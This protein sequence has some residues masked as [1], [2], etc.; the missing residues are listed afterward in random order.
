MHREGIKLV[1]YSA[2][3]LTPKQNGSFSGAS[4]QL[5]SDRTNNGQLFDVNQVDSLELNLSPTGLL[6]IYYRTWNFDTTWDL[7][8]K[9]AMMTKYVPYHGIVTLTFREAFYNDIIQ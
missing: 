8:C 9:G 6:H 2:G 4:N 7:S 1:S 3:Y 5:F